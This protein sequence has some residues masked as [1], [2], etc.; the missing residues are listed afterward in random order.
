MPNA[1]CRTRNFLVTAQGE[2]NARE[3]GKWAEIYRRELALVWLGRELPDWERPCPIKV[4]FR[5][6]GHSGGGATNFGFGDWLEQDSSIEGPG[7]R[8]AL[9]VLPHEITHMIFAHHL[10]RPL[11]RWVDEGGAQVIESPR[12]RQFSDAVAREFVNSGRR[13]PL[14]RLVAMKDYP[15]DGQG[16]AALYSQSYSICDLLCRRGDGPTF[17]RFVADSLGGD[18]DRALSR[19]YRIASVEQLESIWIQDL[20]RGQHTAACPLRPALGIRH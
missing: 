7:D 14:R 8:L 9:D 16:V 18:W 4:T 2:A 3:L 15:R 10:R 13:I 17:L 5:L 20:R 1:Q 11:P 12:A 19:H 6:S